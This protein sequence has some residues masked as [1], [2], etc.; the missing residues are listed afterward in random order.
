MVRDEPLAAHEDVEMD[1]RVEAKLVLYED[2]EGNQ[3]CPSA[4]GAIL[5][6]DLRIAR[7]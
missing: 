3:L 4:E 1:E 5:A 6:G 2:E 7:G